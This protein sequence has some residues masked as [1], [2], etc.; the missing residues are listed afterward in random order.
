MPGCGRR[1]A[2]AMDVGTPG[3]IT[4][5]VAGLRGAGDYTRAMGY[6]QTLAVVRGV[7][8][9]EAEAD[10]LLLELEL[11]VGPEGFERFAAAGGVLQL[12]PSADAGN[13]RYVLQP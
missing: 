13:P 3:P 4:I 9:L 12:E 8:V 7:R 10:H 2:V 11:A 5:E 6:L 1:D